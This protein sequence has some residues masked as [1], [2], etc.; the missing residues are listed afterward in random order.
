MTDR[1]G[2]SNGTNGGNGPNKPAAGIS[3][4]EAAK[5]VNWLNKSTGHTPAYKFG[6]GGAFG[7]VFIDRH[8]IIFL[9]AERFG[10]RRQNGFGVMRSDAVIHALARDILGVLPDRLA[11][12][13]PV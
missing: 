4:L 3:W 1:N 10:H 2:S 9:H 6:A 5:F 12:V 8:D 13:S 7:R 11:V